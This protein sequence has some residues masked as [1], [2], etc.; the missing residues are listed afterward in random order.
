MS[1]RI[2]RAFNRS[3]TTRAV[4]LDIFK[5][6]NRVWHAGLLHKHKSHEISGQI[7]GLISSFFGHRWLWVLF[8]GKSA[9]EYLVN[10]GVPQGS[11]V[12]PTLHLLYI[13]DLLDHVICDIA[14]CADDTLY[15]KFYQAFDFWQELQLASELESDLHDHVD[16]GKKW[17]VYFNAR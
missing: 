8:S 4:A 3:Q 13:N 7:I 17:L 12:G 10:A 6:S 2:A 16:W 1:D 5:A 14:I 15:C 11:I 9:Y